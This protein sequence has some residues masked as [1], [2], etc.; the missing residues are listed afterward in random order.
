MKAMRTRVM[1]KCRKA[2]GYIAALIIAL[3]VFGD[4]SAKTPSRVKDPELV[5]VELLDLELLDQDGRKVKFRSEVIG[6]RIVVINTFYTACTTVCPALI[7][8]F[9]ELQDLLGEYLGREVVLVSLSVDPRTD[10][11]LRLKEFARKQKA[12]PGWVFLTG[13]RDNLS[14]VLLGLDA[15]SLKIDEH[16][17][18]TIIGDNKTGW[19]RFYGFAGPRQLMKH[20]AALIE[21]RKSAALQQKGRS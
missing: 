6:D 5:K 14:R 4:A 11:P 18:M 21:E 7:Y 10:T 9:V 3:M 12:K 19:K 13:D 16:P 2:P 1:M 15:Y 20:I 17:V 8:I